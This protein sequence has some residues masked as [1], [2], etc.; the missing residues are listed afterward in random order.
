MGIG[1]AIVKGFSLSS[2]FWKVIAIFFVVNVVM[3]LI[4]LPFANPEN[5]ETPAIGVAPLVLSIVFFFIFIFLQGGTLGLVKDMH[6]SGSFAFSNFTVYGKKYYTKILGLFLLYVLIAIALVLILALAGSGLLALVNNAFMRALVLAVTVVVGTIA[7]IL[8]LY[9]IYSIVADE[10]SVM[11]AFK[12][13]VA[14]SRSTFGKTLLLFLA[15]VIISLLVSLIIGF[16]IGL[17]TVPLPFAVTRV[18]ITIVNS[19]VQSYIPIVMMIALMGF[20][21]SLSKETTGP[22]TTSS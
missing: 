2:K 22:P 7:I 21:M 18:I 8:L 3:G 6:K 14:T 11:E 13:G 20:Y 10:K 1:E 16:I 19:A 9:P 12:H 15:L 4:S 17:I 5:T